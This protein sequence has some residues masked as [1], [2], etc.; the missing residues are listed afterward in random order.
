MVIVGTRPNFVKVTRFRQVADAHHDFRLQLV[1]TGQHY[2]HAMAK[3]FFEQFRLQP[4]V[5]LHTE[6]GPPALQVGHNVVALAKLFLDQK[7]DLVM[8]VGDV[9]TTLAGAIAANKCAIPLAH[10]ESGLRSGDLTMPEE[11]NRRIADALSA[12]HFI[13]EESGLVNLRTEGAPEQGLCFAGNT[14]I[15]TL[16]EYR[17]SI[18]RSTVQEV[19]GLQVRPFG[20]VTLHR[21]SNV[22][23]PEG[24]AFMLD[25]LHTAAS[26]GTLVFP[27]HPRT[28]QRLEEHRMWS[29][30][31]SIP[32][33]QCTEPL[34]YFDFQHLVAA[35]RFVLTDSGG[36]QEETTYLGKPC[37]TLR[38]NT[39]RPVTVTSGT[40]TLLP[41]HTD[42]IRQALQ[43]IVDGTYKQ[44]AVPPL[45]DGHA[46]ERVLERVAL[47]FE[48]GW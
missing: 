32:S 30:L 16:V 43:S 46:T 19:L 9:N 2:D 47:Y 6:P 21:P 3:V 31:Q 33:L 48:Q 11:H 28:R 20:L 23:S 44:G 26:F 18:A 22:D 35:S 8:V 1:H 24:L 27:M 7:P 40:N 4:D 5:W 45:W 36:L 29:R 17:E 25:V 37:L 13:T 15:D 41:L 14:M 42:A 39:E 12:L 10:L 38:P 34:G